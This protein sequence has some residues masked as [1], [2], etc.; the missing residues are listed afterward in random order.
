MNDRP[1]I[2]RV[3][4]YDELLKKLHKVQHQID[5]VQQTM[6][7]AQ[8]QLKALVSKEKRA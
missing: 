1:T 4:F 2:E 8:Y 7:K 3:L 6:R 5:D